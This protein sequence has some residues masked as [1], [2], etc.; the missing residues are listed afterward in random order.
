VQPQRPDR[1]Q[2][3]PAVSL[4]AGL[5]HVFQV[6]IVQDP[7]T[8]GRNPYLVNG[9]HHPRILGRADIV[10]G[11]RPQ[12]GDA[13]LMEQGQAGGLT[14]R[15]HCLYTM[16]YYPGRTSFKDFA[17]EGTSVTTVLARPSGASGATRRVPISGT[18]II[19]YRV[20]GGRQEDGASLDVQ[21]ESCQ[22]YCDDHG[23]EVVGEF[24]DIESGLH[25]DRPQYMRAVEV[26]RAKGA[27]KV[28]V[29]RYDRLGRDSA[30][31]IPLLKGLKR[32][33]V[34]V[35]SVTQPTESIFMQ[36]VIGIMAEEESRQLS[37]RVTASKQRRLQEG[38]W[39]VAPPF[40]Y[41]NEKHPTGG[42]VLVP[43]NDAPFVREIFTRYA[44][45][46]HSLMD[47]RR[48]LN[49]CGVL[50]GRSGI[51]Y[52]LRNRTYLGE[53]PHGRFSRSEFFAKPEATW[54]QGEHEALVDPETFAQV[55]ARLEGNAHRKTGGVHPKFLFSGLVYCGL[56]GHKF[57]GRVT[58]NG[59]GTKFVQFKC[60]RRTGFGDCKSP[61]VLE[62]RIREAAIPKLEALLGQLRQ[63][64]LRVAVREEL[65]RQQQGTQ[66]ATQQT[67]ESLSEN[68]RRLEARLSKVE[69]SFLDGA[70]D[71]ERYLTRRDEIKSQLDEVKAQLTARPQM[72]LPNVEQFFALADAVDIVEGAITIAGEAVSDQW[73]RDVI[74]GL[75][76]KVVIEV[77]NIRVV[78][79][80]AFMPLMEA[81]SES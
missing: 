34:D 9:L 71:R 20:S 81:V 41:I 23:L 76:E 3:L 8:H 19:Y 66:E 68:Q 18:A 53:V 4:A 38:K 77:R 72:A 80:D 59:H 42:S 67:K 58:A 54:R 73:W 16:V 75:V 46:K 65:T 63:E 78:W 12:D 28:V 55:Q 74:E 61:S 40:G 43:S 33:G 62:T 24:R 69:D 25:A 21:R 79:K 30:E 57:N 35:V 32:L 56:C 44:S 1:H 64:D 17:V 26:A 60:G 22:R 37:T 6:S 51:L 10:A 27:D 15:G 13:A 48:Y 36:Q 14:G 29:W 11:I 39:S 50:K 45:G 49:E 2:E 52:I 31:Y 70:M 7:Q 5:R 47:L